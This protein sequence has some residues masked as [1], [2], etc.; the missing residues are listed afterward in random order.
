M[1]TVEE[2]IADVLVDIGQLDA[3]ESASTDMKNSAFR[4]LNRLVGGLNAEGAYVPSLT[5]VAIALTG[6][7][8]YAVPT[9]PLKIKAASVEVTATV[10]K[11]VEV[12]DAA[13]WAQAPDKAVTSPHA[14]VAYYEDGLPT[15]KL[16]FAPR[17]TTGG[18]LE[19]LSDKSVRA[20]LMEVRETLSLTGASSYT[21]GVGGTF[22]TE[23]PVN[24]KGL[25][26]SA[27]VLDSRGIEI[28]DASK[29]AAFAA[30]GQTSDFA[31]VL[32]YDGSVSAPTVYVGPKPGTGSLVLYNYVALAA[33][34]ALA[35]S[36][37]LPQG[38]EEALRKLLA[39]DQAMS[40]GRQDLIPALSEAAANAKMAIFGLNQSVLGP[41]GAPPLNAND[42]PP[43]APPAQ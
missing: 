43:A 31:E 25:A 36:I 42:A 34:A 37:D 17:P 23:R 27:S 28:V 1:A 18:T 14:R 8:S 2:F 35:T 30:K 41:V 33:F 4:A 21:V 7:Q 39:L 10:S 40:Y 32:Y 20:G 5:R 11:P 22:A 16:H 24:L 29:W 13:T 19:M 6:A 38:Y 3:G 9:R 15:G 12:V 26:I